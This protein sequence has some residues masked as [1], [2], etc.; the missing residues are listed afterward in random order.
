[1]GLTQ[2]TDAI[3]KNL[4]RNNV[5]II[6]GHCIIGMHERL[7]GLG[8]LANDAGGMRRRRMRLFFFYCV[9]VNHIVR[10]TW[11]LTIQS[12][13]IN[14]HALIVAVLFV[15]SGT[16]NGSSTRAKWEAVVPQRALL[17][18]LLILPT[19]LP[20]YLYHHFWQY[21]TAQ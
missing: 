15:S 10:G 7:I 9:H 1:M 18:P 13:W 21:L 17:Y 8:H 14:C 3:W 2:K 12:I 6:V 11:V 20:T 4:I 16:S 5:I 19:F